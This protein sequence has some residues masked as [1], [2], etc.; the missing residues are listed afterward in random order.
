MAAPH[1]EQYLHLFRNIL[2]EKP[3]YGVKIVDNLLEGLKQE[4]LPS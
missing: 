4:V 1:L 2:E 3:K